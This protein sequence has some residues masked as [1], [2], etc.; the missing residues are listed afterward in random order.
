[1]KRTC[2][3]APLMP[4]TT[5]SSHGVPLRAAAYFPDVTSLSSWDTKT[6]QRRCA[7]SAPRAPSRAARVSSKTPRSAPLN[8]MIRCSRLLAVRAVCS[9][10]ASSRNFT[11]EESLKRPSGEEAPWS[12]FRSA[13]MSCNSC[14]S[15]STESTPASV[16]ALRSS[17]RWRHLQCR[18]RNRFS[19]ACGS[20]SPA[21]PYVRTQMSQRS[22][23]GCCAKASLSRWRATSNRHWTYGCRKTPSPWCSPKLCHPM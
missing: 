16:R 9:L 10:Q 5:R 17:S 2:K 19:C 7:S 14:L 11:S 23:S 12:F 22:S 6:T 13:G 8:S 18:T 4:W 15:L 21:R 3:C 1:M 20:G